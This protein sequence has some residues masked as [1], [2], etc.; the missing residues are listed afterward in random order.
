MSETGALTEAGVRTL[1]AIVQRHRALATG[2][3][4]RAA[5]VR[6]AALAHRQCR[7]AVDDLVN[8]AA[9]QVLPYAA[10]EEATVY[11]AARAHHELAG[12]AAGMVSDHE[13]LASMLSRL[14]AATSTTAVLDGAGGLVAV[15]TSHV[16]KEETLVLPRLLAERDVD[17]AKFVARMDELARRNGATGALDLRDLAPPYRQRVVS[18]RFGA[19]RPGSSFTLVND[20]DPAPVR[21]QLESR[22]TGEVIWEVLQAGPPVWRARIGRVGMGD[23]TAA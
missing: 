16:A 20:H 6:E 9:E 11:V 14:T 19:L 15:F 4:L 22:H 12:A 2:L 1:Q 5:D 8:Y 7:C 23:R 17:P 10:A 13:Y 18:A 3:S 21:H